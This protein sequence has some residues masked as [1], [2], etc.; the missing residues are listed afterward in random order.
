MDHHGLCSLCP[1]RARSVPEGNLEG[2]VFAV[3]D[4]DV[5]HPTAIRNFQQR[6][7]QTPRVSECFGRAALVISPD[8]SKYSVLQWLKQ[9]NEVHHLFG[10]LHRVGVGVGD[11]DWSCR[12]YKIAPQ[13]HETVWATDDPI[14]E[15]NEPLPAE[16]T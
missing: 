11:T 4:V 9:F 6:G 7:D 13:E 2:G 10:R 16:V 1:T 14:P 12:I 5:L 8:R 3:D 15:L